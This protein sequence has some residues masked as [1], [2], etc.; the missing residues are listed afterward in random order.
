MI[1]DPVIIGTKLS[2]SVSRV[3]LSDQE[4]CLLEHVR[5]DLSLLIFIQYGI[6]FSHLFILVVPNRSENTDE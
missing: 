1:A 5:P 4:N 6:T 2:A 3:E